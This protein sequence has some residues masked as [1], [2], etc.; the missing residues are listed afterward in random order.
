MG[1]LTLNGSFQQTAGGIFAVDLNSPASADR[2]NI[3]G[4][5]TLGGTLALNCAGACSFAIGDSVTILDASASLS[6]SIASVTMQGFASGAFSVVCGGASVRLVATQAVS[7][8]PEP[9]SLARMPCWPT[10]RGC[11]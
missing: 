1:L 6:G 11:V 10:V 2:F 9:A 4:P 7:A 8:V 5:A 3:T